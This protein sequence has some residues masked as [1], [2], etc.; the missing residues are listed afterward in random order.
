MGAMATT[1]APGAPG[2]AATLDALL[3]RL[4]ADRVLPV[5]ALE[6]AATAPALAAALADGGL[7]TIEITFRTPAAAA[8]IAAVRSARPAHLVGAGTILHPSQADDAVAAGAAFLVTP[9]TNPRVLD[10]ALALGIPVVPGIATPTELEAVLERG[11][12]VA[13][14]FPAGPLG[15]P[16][17]ARALAG[18][19][20]MARLLPTGGIGPAELAAWLAVP[21][22]L[23]VGGSWLAPRE[24]LAEGELTRVRALAAEA[25]AVARDAAPPAPLPGP[26]GGGAT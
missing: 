9:G 5:V 17:Y 18:P 25:V 2:G 22:V 1:D 19:Y 24:A 21:T 7:G 3:R 13:K 15:G 26:P 4:A 11:L 14:L 12:R 20:P 10:H 16:A 8:A 23:A 6:E